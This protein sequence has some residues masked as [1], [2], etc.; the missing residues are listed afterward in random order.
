MSA[1][2][3]ALKD[4]IMAGLV[5]GTMKAALMKAAASYSPAHDFYDDISADVVATATVTGKSVSSGVFDAGDVLFADVTTG[6]TVDAVVLYLD[7]GTPGTSRL[8]AWIDGASISTNGGNITVT[9]S[10][11]AAKIFAL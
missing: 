8:V 9:W 7:T 11:G 5:S 10:N 2:Y 6:E 4:N 3:P 1:V